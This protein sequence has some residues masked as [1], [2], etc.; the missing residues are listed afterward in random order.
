LHSRGLGFDSPQFQIFYFPNL[1]I[2]QQYSI[3]LF[4]KQGNAQEASV[5]SVYDF[6]YTSQSLYLKYF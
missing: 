5:N 2:Y 3:A 6:K 4:F 1:T